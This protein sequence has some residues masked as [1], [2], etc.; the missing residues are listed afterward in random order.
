MYPGTLSDQG[1]PRAMGR[2][3]LEKSGRAHPSVWVVP[4]L[5]VV[6]INTG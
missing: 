3:D 5:L 4:A 1:D 6:F 2:C